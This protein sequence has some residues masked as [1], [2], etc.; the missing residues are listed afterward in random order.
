[1]AGSG[2]PQPPLP[3]EDGQNSWRQAK[4]ADAT[5]LSCNINLREGIGSAIMTSGIQFNAVT[6]ARRVLRLATTGA[7]A[8]VAA[9]G[10]PFAS[11]VTVATTPEGEPILLIST[12]AR[13]T[14][15]IARD[16]RVSLL[17]VAPG[18]EDGD[19]LAGARLSLT[20]TI[21]P[22][23][24]ANHHRR[25]LARHPEATGYATFT[26]FDFCRISVTAAHHVAGFGRIVDLTPGELLTDC[27]DC[28]A[29]IAAEAEAIAH[30]NEDHADAPALYATRLLGM[31]EGKWTATGA[32]PGGLDL[33]AGGLTA[34][35]DFPE[36]VRNGSALRAVLV[37][38]AKEARTKT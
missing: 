11:L 3:A 10:A 36:K 15:N 27:S 31:P 34:R 8:T 29:T 20:G 28:G 6:A 23:P 2:F 9:D 35:L 25:F 32:D 26:D 37:Q 38:L 33:R 30:M 1:V 18:G 17:L 16:N 7:L 12:L 13:H 24:D 14:Q 22:D 5:G 21:A 4:P 19:P